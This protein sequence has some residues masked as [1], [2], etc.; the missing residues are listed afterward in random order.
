VTELKELFF[1]QYPTWAE[2]IAVDAV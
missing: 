1:Q 2:S